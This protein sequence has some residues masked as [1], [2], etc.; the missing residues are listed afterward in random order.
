MRF[1]LF[2]LAAPLFAQCTG[3]STSLPYQ[4]PT[5]SLATYSA[6]V[7]AYPVFVYVT[8]G[9]LKTTANGGLSQSAGNDIRFADATG[10]FFLQSLV[11]YSAT[12]GVWEGY[13]QPTGLSQYGPVPIRICI[14]KASDSSHSTSTT[15]PATIKAMFPMQESGLPWTDFSQTAGNTTGGTAPTQISGNLGAL[16]KAQSFN[17]TTQFASFAN[18]LTTGTDGSLFTYAKNVTSGGS[19]V[20]LENRI[21]GC[22]NGL[23]LFATGSTGKGACY[24]QALSATAAGSTDLRGSWHALEC[25]FVASSKTVVLYVDGVVDGTVTGG[26]GPF[27]AFAAGTNEI[28]QGCD[29][30]LAPISGMS[31]AQIISGAEGAQIVQ[32]KSAAFTS[33]TTF[34]VNKSGVWGVSM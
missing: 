3:Y 10:A 5:V 31:H 14:G 13:I 9:R 15:F 11:T 6:T 33:P 23:V 28:G 18:P 29:A 21:S 7:S 17:G 22:T 27:D 16:D 19:P 2:L 30:S 4:L 1:A 12:S 26:A 25:T 34:T 8:D 24:A 32:A 20:M